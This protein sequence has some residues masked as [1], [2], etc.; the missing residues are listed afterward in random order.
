MVSGGEGLEEMKMNA[1]DEIEKVAY[2][3]WETSGSIHGRDVE[4][5]LEAEKIVTERHRHAVSHDVET[6]GQVPD[7]GGQGDLKKRRG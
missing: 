6:Q 5:W 1:H 4:F 2:E 3:L 7:S